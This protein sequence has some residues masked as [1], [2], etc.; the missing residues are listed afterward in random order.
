VARRLRTGSV[1]IN[2]V[3]QGYDAPFGGFKQSGK[4][5]RVGTVRNRRVPRVQG[6]QRILRRVICESGQ[7]AA[8]KTIAGAVHG[9]RNM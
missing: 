1:Y 9:I 7:L 5:A 8:G 4:R 6:H 3:G 2:G